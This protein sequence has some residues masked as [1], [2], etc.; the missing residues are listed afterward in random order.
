MQPGRG[1][2]LAHVSAGPHP[3]SVSFGRGRHPIA[4]CER[5]CDFWAWP[6]KYRVLVQR[7]EGPHDDV[8]VTL[9][10]RRPSSYVFVPADGAGQ[11]AGLILGVSGPVIGFV[12]LVLTAAGLFGTCSDPSPGESCDGKPPAFYIGLGT[13]AAG[14][15][16]TAVG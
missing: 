12:G 10:I 1:M 2:V 14:A 15:T 8:A 6:G 4:S 3:F 9:N 5:E 16:M 7:G 11:N 13:L